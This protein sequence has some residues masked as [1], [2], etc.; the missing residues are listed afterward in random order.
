VS[1]KSVETYRA[2]LMQKLDMRKRADLVRFALEWGLL[3]KD[4]ANPTP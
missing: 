4:K 1:A 2:R 3:S